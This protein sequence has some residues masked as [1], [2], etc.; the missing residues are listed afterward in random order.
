MILFVSKKGSV[1]VFLMT[2]LASI[3]LLVALFIHAAS[4]A[5]GRSYTD[6]VLDLAG[7]SV[8]SEY[9]LQLQKR[10]GIFAFHTDESKAKEKV[11][12]Y[13]DYSFHDNILKEAVRGRAFTDTLKLDLESVH[14]NLKGYSITDIDLFEAQIMDYM[15]YDVIMSGR[16]KSFPHPSSQKDIVLRNERS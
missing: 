12:Y 2:I 6:A 1:S 14:V 5:A 13:A 7:R 8:L 4:Q 11:K 16:K 10:Y 15:K 9:D 3:L